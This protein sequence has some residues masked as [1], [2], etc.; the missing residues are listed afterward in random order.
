M[1]DSTPGGGATSAG[2]GS[3]PGGGDGG[4]SVSR[5][6]H[7][8][9][10]Q[11]GTANQPVLALDSSIFANLGPNELHQINV[12]QLEFARDVSASAASSYEKILDVLRG[13]P[14]NAPPPAMDR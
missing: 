11:A 8:G 13:A 1:S 14:Q 5:S 9:G 4:P 3:Q 7:I 2:K 10:T 6:R 12:A